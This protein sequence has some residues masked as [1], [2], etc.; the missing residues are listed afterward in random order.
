MGG[1]EGAD[2]AT[3]LWMARAQ[4]RDKGELL[5]LGQALVGHRAEDWIGAELKRC[6][7][8]FAE[9]SLDRGGEAN[10]LAHVGDPV[11]GIGCLFLGQ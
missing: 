11:A 6:G 4:S 9:Q 3:C 10:R 2:G 8:A 7:G 1:G 5:T